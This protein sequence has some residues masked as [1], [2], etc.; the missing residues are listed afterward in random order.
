LL[1]GPN[2]TVRK[3]VKLKGWTLWDGTSDIAT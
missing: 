3:T 2:G 1:T